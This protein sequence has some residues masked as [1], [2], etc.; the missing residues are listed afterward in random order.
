MLQP[1]RLALALALVWGAATRAEPAP[2]AR[3]R[4]ERSVAIASTSAEP[5]PI[6]RVAG[7][8][9]TVF[10]FSSPIQ[11]KTLTFDESRIRVLDAGERSVIVQPVANLAAGERQEIGVFFADGRAPTR[12]AF[13][14]VTD[15]AEVDSRIDVQRPEPP[16]TAC[17]PTAQ[18][19]APR[20]EDF[21]LLGYV[22]AKGVTTSSSKGTL[23]AVQG[24]ILDSIVAFRGA[25]WILADVKIVNRPDHPAWT[26][27]EAMFVGRVG[28]PL[29]ARLVAEKPGAILP[30]ENGRVLAVV[31]VPKTKADLVFTLE[32]RGDGERRLTI[33]DVRFPKPAAEDAQ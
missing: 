30:G 11:K 24:L 7:D 13:V 29:R 17:Q 1:F 4:R 33:P 32:V 12:A 20:P 10:L 31:E 23:D 26:P 15:P 22:D 9:P 6:V 27:R 19:P 2:G 14:L 21:V 18:V 3:G 28:M 25:G 16:N 5:L 8:T